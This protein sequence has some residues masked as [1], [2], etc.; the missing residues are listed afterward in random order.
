MHGGGGR[1]RAFLRVTSLKS[2]RGA[3]EDPLPRK[4]PVW[5]AGVLDSSFV[6]ISANP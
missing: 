5:V 6:A 4:K 1:G 3:S 2:L